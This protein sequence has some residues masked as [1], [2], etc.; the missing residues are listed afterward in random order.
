M[1][2]VMSPDAPEEETRGAETAVRLF[3]ARLHL[4][5]R[6]VRAEAE[7]IYKGLCRRNRGE[8]ANG[9]REMAYIISRTR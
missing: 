5:A 7:I 4:T 6:Q 8:L 2:R 3:N 1:A 9:F